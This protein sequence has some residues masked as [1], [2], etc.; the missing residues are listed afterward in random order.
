MVSVLRAVKPRRSEQYDTLW[1]M[2]TNYFLDRGVLELD[3]G[4]LNIPYGLVDDA[5]E[6]MLRDVL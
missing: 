2:Q 3:G 6:A 1:L 4:R 5:G